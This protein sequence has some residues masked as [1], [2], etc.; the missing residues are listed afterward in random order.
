MCKYVI[1]IQLTAGQKYVSVDNQIK[2]LG[3]KLTWNCVRKVEIC[4]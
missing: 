4:L 1:S 2:I 3:N